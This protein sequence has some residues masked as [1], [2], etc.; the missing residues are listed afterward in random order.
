MDYLHIIYYYYGEDSQLRRL[1]LHHS[2]QV[3]DRCL[4]IAGRHPELSLDAAFLEPAA[5]LHDIGI[6]R[7]QAPSIY[8]NGTEPYICHG[9]IGAGMLRSLP[10]SVGVPERE[11]EGFARV[12]ER[13]TGTGLTRLQIE[14]RQLPLPPRDYVPQTLEEQVVCY[15]DK[16]YSKSHPERC[17]TVEQAARS[18]EKFGSEGVEK[19]LRWSEMFE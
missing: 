3:A 8:C 6:C 18:L 1:L 11:L 4:L 19:F 14:S 12:C 13:H 9:L 2:R 7:C 5:M 16:F 10:P 17:L 15:A